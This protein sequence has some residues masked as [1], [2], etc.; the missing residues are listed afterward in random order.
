MHTSSRYRLLYDLF[1]YPILFYHYSRIE[2]FIYVGDVLRN[3]VGETIHQS[4]ARPLGLIPWDDL[5]YL[6]EF[7]HSFSPGIAP[8]GCIPINLIYLAARH[9]C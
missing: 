2:I 8:D 7:W 5:P 1:V 3:H 9:F 6:Q 4:A